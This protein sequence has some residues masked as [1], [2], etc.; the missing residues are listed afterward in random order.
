VGAWE[1]CGGARPGASVVEE[2]RGDIAAAV[3]GGDLPRDGSIR[4]LEQGAAVEKRPATAVPRR[5]GIAGAL[6]GLAQLG[7]QDCA[8]LRKTDNGGH[9]DEYSVAALPAQPGDYSVTP[10]PAPRTAVYR[11]SSAVW[12]LSPAKVILRVGPEPC[13]GHPARPSAVTA[14]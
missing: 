3:E 13:E 14:H 6:A 10:L 12:G 8:F 1:R 9:P 11:R 4:T 7:C 5:F 2:R